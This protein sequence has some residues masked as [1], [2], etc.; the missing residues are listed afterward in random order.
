MSYHFNQL[1][2]PKT[3][4]EIKAKAQEKIKKL[5]AKID[6]RKHFIA[7]QAEKLGITSVEAALTRAEEIGFDLNAEDQIAHS[8]LMVNRNK[9]KAEQGEV[10][11]LEMIVRNLPDDRS[12]NLEFDAL[13]Y[14]GF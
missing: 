13:R 2:F 12:F 10:R 6:E 4:V 9:S 3:G 11:E 8:K 7:D 14:F 1:R 5:Q